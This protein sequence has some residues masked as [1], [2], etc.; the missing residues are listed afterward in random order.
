MR[1]GTPAL[2]LL[3]FFGCFAAFP[4]STAAQLSERLERCLP[5][6]TF[7]H[8]VEDVRAARGVPNVVVVDEVLFDGTNQMPA[9]ERVALVK[10]L[11]AMHVTNDEDGVTEQEYEIEKWW[12]DNGYFRAELRIQAVPTVLDGTNQHVSLTI[13]V[14]EGAQYRL[15]SVNFRSSEPDQALVFPLNQLMETVKMRE[16]DIFSSARLRDTLEQLKRLYVSHGYIDFVTTPITEINE[17]THHRIDLM[18]ELDQEKQYRIGSV[19][20]HAANPRVRDAIA[21]QIKTGDIFDDTTL[22]G[23]LK[24]NAPLLPP[25]ISERDVKFGRDKKLGVVNLWFELESCTPL[26][27]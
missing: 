5:T 27:Q 9:A 3:A 18:L 19:E 7:A 23:V 26:P 14:D 10:K 8:E 11:K 1:A 25:D 13:H 12:K 17:A 16:S 24:Q 2:S 15:G 22:R 6:P 4:H 21:A 20:V